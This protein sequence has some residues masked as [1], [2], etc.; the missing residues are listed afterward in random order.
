MISPL[1]IADQK[2]LHRN[3]NWCKDLPHSSLNQ[4]GALPLTLADFGLG[5][6]QQENQD[7]FSL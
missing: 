1:T 3:Q 6:K 4:L 7:L 5:P 2:S